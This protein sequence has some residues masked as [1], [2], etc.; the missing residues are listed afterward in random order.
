MIDSDLIY[1]I[2]GLIIFI[3]GIVISIYLYK[4]IDNIDF[5]K[6]KEDKSINV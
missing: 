1:I 2:I 6:Q 4:I 5:D 3:I